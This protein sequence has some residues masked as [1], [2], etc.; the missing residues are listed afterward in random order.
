MTLTVI[1]ALCCV[2]AGVVLC[3]VE[4]S[5]RRK[6]KRAKQSQKVMS[7]A[8]FEKDKNLY[9]SL[10]TDTRFVMDANTEYPCLNDKYAQNG[11]VIDN[12]YY[13]QDIWG[14]RKVYE[15][16]P[17]VHYDV[18]SSVWGFIAHL[19][20]I[21]QRIVLLDIRPMNN[22]F[23]TKFLRGEYA[24]NVNGGGGLT[25]IQAD[26]T[27]LENIKDNSLESLS[28]LCSVEHFG[29]GRFGD[30]IDPMAWEKALK[31]FQRVLRPNGK[32]Y[33]SVPVGQNNKVCFNAHR[34]YTPQIIIDTLNECE[35][36]EM[37]Y[38]DGFDTKMCIWHENGTL[39]IDEKA[40]QDI[41]DR[42]KGGAV[43]LFEFKKK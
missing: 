31:A 32:L 33:F 12:S 25:Y 17:S 37:S 11:G 40:L 18:G 8:E 24:H 41:P 38:I 15:N 23:N 4:R 13:I 1:E 28:A 43:G 9:Q 29:L 3:R 16:R 42:Q 36:L 10:N 26:A 34:V 35:I 2:V 22:D 27:N 19:F 39:K 21:N 30:S 20:G 5:I 14:A 6:M 7:K